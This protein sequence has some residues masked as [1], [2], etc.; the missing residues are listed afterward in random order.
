MGTFDWYRPDPPLAC[1]RCGRTLEEWQGKDGPC[2]LFVWR[3]GCI[4]P[5]DQPIDEDVRLPPRRREAWRLPP[6]FR[7]DS[8]DCPCERRTDAL[9]T[10]EDGAWSRTTV[11][12]PEADA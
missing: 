8:H 9:G 2:A 10:C 6:S 11:V 4:A 1:P 3:Q 7:I 12:D 5:V